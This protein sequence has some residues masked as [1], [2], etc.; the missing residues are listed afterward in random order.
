MSSRPDRP[1]T[2]HFSGL[3]LI[4]SD[5]YNRRSLSKSKSKYNYILYIIMKYL[6][7]DF[8]I[9]TI[10]CPLITS[11]KIYIILLIIISLQNY[12][13]WTSNQKFNPRTFFVLSS[14]TKKSFRAIKKEFFFKTRWR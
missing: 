13:L 9:T 2:S 3:F 1:G 8:E 10:R 6:T 12:G 11:K 7:Y 4:S 14:E 5:M